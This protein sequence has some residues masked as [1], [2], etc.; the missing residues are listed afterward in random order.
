[1][2][3][4]PASPAREQ[5]KKVT[6]DHNL[7]QNNMIAHE[8]PASQNNTLGTSSPQIGQKPYLLDTEEMRRLQ[9]QCAHE[10]RVFANSNRMNSL[11]QM[12]NHTTVKMYT[13]YVI[14]GF[15]RKQEV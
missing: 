7:P 11:E 13:Y 10:I 6:K 12:H 8:T 3:T 5:R 14:T 2:Q 15:I 4:T 9:Q 1:M